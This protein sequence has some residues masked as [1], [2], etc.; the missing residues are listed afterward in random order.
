[1][2]D[3]LKYYIL[4]LLQEEQNQ[5]QVW[6]KFQLSWMG[7]IVI[8]KMKILPNIFIC[9]SKF[10]HQ[11]STENFQKI[12]TLFTKFIWGYEHLRIGLSTLQS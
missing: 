11:Y 9:F 3:L 1:M 5:S 6:D 7:H 4:V 10:N 8:I 12:Q 2:Q